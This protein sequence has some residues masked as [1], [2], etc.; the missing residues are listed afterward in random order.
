MSVQTRHSVERDG[1]PAGNAPAR[2]Y[3]SVNTGCGT[4]VTQPAI[5]VYPVI[6]AT[7]AAATSV[8][9]TAAG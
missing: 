6:P 7:V 3:K 8:R 4:S 9:T 1:R 5:A 2:R